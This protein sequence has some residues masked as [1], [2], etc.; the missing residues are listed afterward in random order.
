MVIEFSKSATTPSAKRQDCA[1]IDFGEICSRSGR[2]RL[3]AECWALFS[4][5][6]QHMAGIQAVSRLQG[7]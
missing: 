5:G 3:L 2:T 7:S 4:T 1:L 6:D